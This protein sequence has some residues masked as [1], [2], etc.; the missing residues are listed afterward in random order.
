MYSHNELRGSRI[1]T[2]NRQSLRNDVDK[3]NTVALQSQK[4]LMS[5]NLVQASIA[6][7]PLQM[8]PSHAR[9]SKKIIVNS[10]T[11]TIPRTAN[12]SQNRI[13]D[14]KKMET[15]ESFQRF[16]QQKL[17][18]REIAGAFQAQGLS[19]EAAQRGQQQQMS[20]ASLH[21]TNHQASSA[22]RKESDQLLATAGAGTAYLHSADN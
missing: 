20:S 11:S 1:P 7:T 9:G 10:L 16:R 22:Y 2:K 21:L 6:E 19:R 18:G 3:Y 5:Y 4:N 15:M 14:A 8:N 13:E 12:N 17:E